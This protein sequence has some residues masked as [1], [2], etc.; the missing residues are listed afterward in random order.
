MIEPKLRFKGFEQTWD[1]SEFSEIGK[2]RKIPNRLV[3]HQNLLSL[4]Y[5]KIVRKDIDS[6]KGLLPAS[7]DTYQIV[8]K[9]TVVFRFT[10]L[11]NDKRSLRVGLSG[12]EGIISP[13]YVCVDVQNMLPQ[14]FFYQMYSFDLRKVFYS[15]GDG[16]R[17]TLSYNEVKEMPVFSPIVAEQKLIVCSIDSIER[18]ISI[19]EKEIMRLRQAIA[20]ALVTMF[21]R[22][23]ELVPR[24]RFTGFDAPWRELHLGEF[25]EKVLDKNSKNDYSIPLT[26]S[27]EYGIIDQLDFFEH[28][29]AKDNSLGHYTIVKPDDFVYNPRISVTAP[30]GPINRNNLGYTGVMSPLYYVFSVYDIEKDFLEVYFKTTLWHKYLKDNGNS[31]ARHDRI[32]ITDDMFKMMPILCPKDKI[33]QQKIAEFF[34]NIDR[35]I[36]IQTKILERLKRVKAACLDQMFV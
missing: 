27:A 14:F 11:Q 36:D 22:K 15:M 33:E 26:N 25:S 10:D 9:D 17:Q 5:G 16:L 23:G 24:V 29:I 32:S 2:Y 7:Y 6:R 12:E 21:P 20:S 30:V 35:Q 13:A 31:G 4:S 3:H 19:V 18:R 8:D 28:N 1:Q 34:Q